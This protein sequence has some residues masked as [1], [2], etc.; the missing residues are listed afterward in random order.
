MDGDVGHVREGDRFLVELVGKREAPT[1]EDLGSW[2]ESLRGVE[3]DT[4][5][6]NE[7]QSASYAEVAVLR[8]TIAERDRDIS[9]ERARSNLLNGELQSAKLRAKVFSAENEL[10]LQAVGH[11]DWQIGSICGERDRL[12]RELAELRNAHALQVSSLEAQVADLRG[13]L[14]NADKTLHSVPWRIVGIWRKLRK[15]IPMPI[16]ATTGRLWRIR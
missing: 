3:V 15:F 1:N 14:A 8:Q 6:L 2:N 7:M 11:R 5:N 13:A 4:V 12:N 10:L 9:R 16:L